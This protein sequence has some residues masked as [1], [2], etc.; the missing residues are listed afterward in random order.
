[1]KYLSPRRYLKIPVLLLIVFSL[2]SPAVK[3]FDTAP[4]SDL[5]RAALSEKGFAND[6][7]N[8]AQLQN[9][10]TDYYSSSP[11]ISGRKRA[12]LEKLHFDNLFDTAQVE[13]YWR[14]FID[15]LRIETV[16]TATADD[17]FR[18]LLVI[19][20]GLHAVQDFYSHSN[21]VET[22]SRQT[23]SVFRT[24]TYLS[25]GASGLKLYTGKYPANRKKGPG[26]SPVPASAAPHG[27]YPSG[28]NKD[29][30]IRPGWD[31]AYVF[32]YAASIETLGLMEKW[33]EKAKPGF[34]KR[35]R[36]YGI[37]T[38]DRTRLDYDLRALR[39]MSMW[40]SGKGQDG[41]WKG[42]KSGSARFFSAFSSKWVGKNSSRFVKAAAEGTVQEELAK[43]LYTADAS[44][45]LPVVPKF[46]LKQRAILLRVT[47]IAEIK[48]QRFG[49]KLSG[50]GGT[51]FYA[52]VSIGGEEYW[53][54]TMQASRTVDD[55]WYVI[56]FADISEISVPV[57]I[58]V[59]DEDD[60][61]SDK[62][63]LIDINAAVGK[64]FLDILFRT[65]DNQ[66]SGDINGLFNSRQRPFTSSGTEGDRALITAFISQAA[67]R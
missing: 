51:D 47:S 10:L 52:R 48:D 28:L 29:S 6:A 50:P 27:A 39:N 43:G 66:V 40:I 5:T 56:H 62:D 60:T 46:S 63:R 1:M 67:L 18:M 36:E 25:S 23:D 8:I 19:G 11:T 33:A 12:E 9:W 53:E 20:V 14:R 49:K 45:G 57:H 65:S 35:V 30:P 26:L 7:T 32:A 13:N 41:H 16:K 4:H 3:A 61:D 22:H 17:P 38:E 58:A 64:K 37:S 31:Q 54:R 15:N 34:W 2:L 59:W 21:W 55:P 42:N 44:P 24:D